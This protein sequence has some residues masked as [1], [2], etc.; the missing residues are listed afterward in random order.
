M[1]DA[2]ARKRRDEEG[3]QVMEDAGRGWRRVVASPKP[4]RIVE[5]A[6]IRELIHQGF[7][8]IAVGGGGIPVVADAEGNLQGVAAVIDKDLASSLLATA[9]RAQLFMISTAV[10]KV[11]LNYGKP[12][13]EWVDHLTLAQA[14]EYL[15]EGGHFAGGSMAPKIQAVVW[16]LENGGRE[17]IVT[18]P[19]NVERALTGETGTRFTPD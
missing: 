4:I 18:N 13:Q 16:Y 10:E 6:A 3:W 11:A 7:V 19:E 8:T 9:L 15:A 1:D 5:E 17:A 14:K 2:E 12:N